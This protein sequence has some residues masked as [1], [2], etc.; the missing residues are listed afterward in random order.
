MP[1]D[2][3]SELSWLPRPPRD[4][5]A[6]SNS[7]LP[8]S[9]QAGH[10]LARLASYAL[11]LN[12]MDCLARL[13]M[14]ARTSGTTLKPLIPFTLGLL[15]N[16]TTDFIVSAL[17]ATGCRHGISLNVVSG[18][19]GQMLQEAISPE[20]AVNS[21]TP[22]A[23]LI[24]VDYRGLP[25]TS[26]PGDLH[27]EHACV[28]TALDQLRSIRQGLKRH[29]KAIC[30]FQ[31]LAPPPEML[32]GSLDGILPGSLSRI[33]AGINSGI[34]EA[35]LGTEDVVL[36][37]AHLA[38]TV[39]LAN[40]HF[41]RDWNLG[42]F[43][44]AHTFLPLYADHVCRIVAAL[45][46]K[47]RRCLVLDLDNTIWGGVI[48]DDGIEGIQIGQGDATGEAFLAVQR[49]ALDLRGRGIV[50]A[51]CSKNEEANARSPFRSHPEM[52]LRE[53]HI[54]VFQANWRDK[55]SNIKAIA[56]ELSLGLE[57]LVFLDDSPVERDAVRQALPEV[58][59][60]ELPDDPSLYARTLA[61]A[62]YFES[63][64]F[65][66]EDAAR[67]DFYKDNARRV[68][69]HQQVG[70]LE[71]YLKSLEMEITFQPFDDLGRGRITQL[72]N[73]S[74][75][76]NL[77]TRRYSETQVAEIQRDPACFA[78]QIRLSDRFGDNGMISVIICREFV[79]GEWE[80]DTWLM[81]CR[82]LGRGVEQM[83]LRDLLENAKRRGIRKLRGTYIPTDRNS[84]VVE[85][86]SRLGF[87]ESGDADN[88]TKFYELDVSS[89]TIPH[90]P[91]KVRCPGSESFIPVQSSTPTFT[92]K[93]AESFFPD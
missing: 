86:Y 46:G 50:L 75:Q 17:T 80:V 65:S 7:V 77:T 53:S 48:G 56:T 58:A 2:L 84:L 27:A 42:K 82:V 37:V 69:L 88:G 44:F 6:L 40:W 14:R 30:I 87:T 54:A 21:A 31:T 38:S 68:S 70:D 73:K 1:N 79:P 71:S 18:N 23:V 66:K 85:H 5:V 52:L 4:F 12:Q 78:R 11:D 67:A 41:P 39:G 28:R 55:P 62:G 60:P 93:R 16:S 10:Q 59:V 63:V 35:V 83:V 92:E 43:P 15:S 29:S 19:Y 74:N 24:A 64:T 26:S 61:A 20:S 8:A 47:S 91:M 90:A 13:H 3:F 72:I 51:I 36:D 33:I 45:R 9:E 57:S 76:F 34:S 25:L 32:F 49:L 22:D 81:S 89:A